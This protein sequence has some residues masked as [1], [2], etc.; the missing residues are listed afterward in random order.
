MGIK[1]SPVVEKLLDEVIVSFMEWDLIVYFYHNQHVC[2]TSI[3]IAK[4]IGRN[5]ADVL[6]SLNLMNSKGI[7]EIKK[8]GRFECYQLVPDNKWM[9]AIKEFMGCLEDRL[10][11]LEVFSLLISHEYR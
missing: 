1:I 8:K 11:R 6:R 5:S 7:L 9:A 2:A 3:D 4:Q 10:C